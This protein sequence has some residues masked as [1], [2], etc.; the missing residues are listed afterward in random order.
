MMSTSAR[1]VAAVTILLSAVMA[2]AAP[3]ADAARGGEVWVDPPTLHC[4]GVRW[5]VHD[6]ANAN[7]AVKVAYRRADATTWK[8]AMDLLRVETEAIFPPPP[9]AGATLYAGSVFDLTPGTD[10]VLR[11]RLTDPDGGGQTFNVKLRTWSEPRAPKPKRVLHVRAGAAAGDGSS[12]KPFASP[13]QA[14]RASRPGD[15]VL[16]HAGTYRGPVRL[17]KSGTPDA[18]IVW[19]GAGDGEAIFD[20]PADGCCIDAGRIRHVFFEGLTVRNTARAMSLNGSS[21]VTVRR[22]RFLGVKSGIGAMRKQ[23]RLFIADCVFVGPRNWTRDGHNP[24]LGE[25]RAVELSGIGHV[26][27]YNRISG[28]RDGVDTRPAQPV[29]GI[30]IHNNDISECTDDGIELDY[31]Q[32]NCRAYRNRITNCFMGITFQPSFG[33]PNYAVRNVM[34][35]V[36]FETFKLHVSP[37]GKITAGGVI[38][39]NTVVRKGPALRVWAGGS[40][41]AGRFVLRNNLFVMGE[42]DRAVDMLTNIARSDWDYDV[43]AG[44]PFK[45]FGKY[46]RKSYPTHKAFTAGTGL[47]A[48]GL[49]INGSAGLFASGLGPP[50]DIRR[51]HPPKMNDPRLAPT[52]PAIDRGVPLPNINDGFRGKAPDAGAFELGDPLP[53]YGPRPERKAR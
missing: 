8:P 2:S 26:V 47:E 25:H 7:A 48:H 10:Y 44:G 6:D 40:S 24:K 30:D 41:R 37:P 12:D 20:G 23:R 51:K 36:T 13:G 27:A 52:S 15:L 50:T 31:S 3:A 33:G 32:S 29:Q 22:C 35:N 28:F 34:Y 18:P 53:H 4:A 5:V 21:Y 19:R 39:H 38:L 43:F 1:A 11:L 42:A 45:L 9:P 14:D 16:L 46:G 17:R 49:V